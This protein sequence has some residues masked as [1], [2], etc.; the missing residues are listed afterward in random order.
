[1]QEG[2]GGGCWRFGSDLEEFESDLEGFGS[3]A[4]PYFFHSLRKVLANAPCLV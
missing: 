3:L 1:M 2:L 4:L